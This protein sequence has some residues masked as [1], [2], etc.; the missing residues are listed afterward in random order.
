[1]DNEQIREFVEI[2]RNV[3]EFERKIV[4]KLWGSILMVFGVLLL[5]AGFVDYTISF[6]T[7][8]KPLI[9]F[10]FWMLAVASGWFF[11]YIH[12]NTFG[13][14]KEILHIKQKGSPKAIILAN[15]FAFIV[16]IAIL[17][18]HAHEFLLGMVYAVWPGSLGIAIIISKIFGPISEHKYPVF[19]M[20]C[21]LI[22]TSTA[23]FFVSSYLYGLILGIGFG[24]AF[25]VYGALLYIQR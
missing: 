25:V 1:M 10:F 6:Y 14:L 7:Q 8:G 12:T 5:N 9:L 19:I 2:F 18:S 22:L 4:S 23:I 3:Q 17:L 11:A 13:Q 20:G 15:I 16:S 21:I 24:T